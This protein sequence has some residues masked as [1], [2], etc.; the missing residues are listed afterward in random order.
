MRL[1]AVWTK[2]L[3]HFPFSWA[4]E[5]THALLLLNATRPHL[6][7]ALKSHESRLTG[8]NKWKDHWER[9]SHHLTSKERTKGCYLQQDPRTRYWMLSLPPSMPVLTFVYL[10]SIQCVMAQRAGAKFWSSS[11][12]ARLKSCPRATSSRTP[13]GATSEGPARR[14]TGARWRAATLCT[15]WSSSWRHWRPAPRYCHTLHRLV[16]SLTL[17]F[18]PNPWTFNTAIVS[19]SP[20]VCCPLGLS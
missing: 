16:H 15:R 2:R 13:S 14:S 10:F 18:L 5:A 20:S 1:V 17:F 6:A 9:K 8:W 4:G 3:T 19:F 12:A 7:S 11:P